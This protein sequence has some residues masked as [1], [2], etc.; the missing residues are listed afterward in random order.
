MSCNTPILDVSALVDSS[1]H[2]PILASSTA[3][4]SKRKGKKGR[5]GS[6]IKHANAVDVNSDDSAMMVTL[7]TSD[8]YIAQARE[9]QHCR[10]EASTLSGHPIRRGGN[11]KGGMMFAQ[12]C[13]LKDTN[14]VALYEWFEHLKYELA[15]KRQM[16][17]TMENRQRK[18][19]KQVTEEDTVSPNI[20]YVLLFD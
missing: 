11:A 13:R 2:S 17:I 16:V 20:S 6:R 15:K 8:E 5:K 10:D 9:M 18:K 12:A 3:A 7:K 19:E 1:N 14:A 4:Q